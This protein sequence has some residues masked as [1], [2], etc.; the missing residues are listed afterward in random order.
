MKVGPVSK[1][2]QFISGMGK[3]IRVLGATGLALAVL[4]AAS[5]ATNAAMGGLE[6]ANTRPYGEKVSISAGEVNVFVTGAWT[7]S[8]EGAVMHDVRR[9]DSPVAGQPFPA[10]LPR[11][12]LSMVRPAQTT[13]AR[14]GAAVVE[15]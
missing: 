6:K 5:A 4:I 14:P 10:A 12:D 13:S 11:W 1:L 15:S 7:V 8:L 2:L 3:V 9:R